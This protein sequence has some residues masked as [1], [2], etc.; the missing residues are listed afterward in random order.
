MIL[1]LYKKKKDK[2]RRNSNKNIIKLSSTLRF[3]KLR[4]NFLVN[5]KNFFSG[6]C[7]VVINVRYAELD[8]ILPSQKSIV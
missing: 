4:Y 8:L 1:Q 5:G 7:F 2:L 6:L 3:K